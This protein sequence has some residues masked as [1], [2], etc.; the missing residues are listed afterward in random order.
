MPTHTSQAT[1]VVQLLLI[2]MTILPNL[3]L[4]STSRRRHRN[5][6]VI[7]FNP[8]RRAMGQAAARKLQDFCKIGPPRVSKSSI[9]FSAKWR[10][11]CHD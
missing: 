7:S 4:H 5:L 1:G 10:R 9:D 11:K 3:V 6:V 2:S 8:R